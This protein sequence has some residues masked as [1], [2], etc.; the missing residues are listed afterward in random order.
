MDDGIDEQCLHFLFQA[1]IDQALRGGCCPMLIKHSDFSLRRNYKLHLNLSSA[2]NKV[3]PFSRLLSV[4]T[5]ISFPNT[6]I[7]RAKAFEC[8]FDLLTVLSVSA[9]LQSRQFV[10]MKSNVR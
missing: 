8:L 2:R 1:T 6:S 3:A 7:L 4:E 5:F 9:T 10:R